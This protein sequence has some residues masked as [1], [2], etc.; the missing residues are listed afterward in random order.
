MLNCGLTD[1]RLVNPR[2][3]WPSNKAI[4]A[5]AGADVVIE[6]ARVFRSTADA[7]ADLQHIYATTARPRDIV[8]PVATPRGAAALIR[9]NE[10]RDEAVGVLFGRERTGLANHDVMLA[11]TIITVPLNPG[12][13]SLNLAMAVLLV[14]YEWFQL[15]DETPPV[16]MPVGDSRPANAFEMGGFLDHLDR[17]LDRSGF[18][19][20]EAMRPSMQRNLHAIFQRAGLTEQEVRSLRGVVSRL[21]GRP[22][23]K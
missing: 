3:G 19:R 7:I 15:A 1:L 2:D 4:A 20:T 13:T 16:E 11:G 9:S 18:Y 21:V 10:A 5:S 22:D 12:Y 6:G 17:E 23:G 8:K 14:G